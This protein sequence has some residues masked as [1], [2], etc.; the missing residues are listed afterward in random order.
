[1]FADRGS[2]TPE[3]CGPKPGWP[4]DQHSYSEGERRKRR[5][6]WIKHGNKA[7][8]KE[9]LNEG[10]CEVESGGEGKRGSRGGE[11]EE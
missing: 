8:D 9:R 2:S 10:K 1:M 7:G 11:G 6:R 3:G 5:E 4:E